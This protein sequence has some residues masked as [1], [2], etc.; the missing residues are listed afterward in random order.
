[1]KTEISID[2]AKAA[3]SLLSTESECS[4]GRYKSYANR[5]YYAAFQ[6]AIAALLGGD[7]RTSSDR[8][9]HAFVSQR[10]RVS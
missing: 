3:E 9:P 2:L 5:C 4:N 6:A 10:S 8:W 7:I 1:M